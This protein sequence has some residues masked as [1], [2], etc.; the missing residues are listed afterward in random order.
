[1]I[2]AMLHP[3]ID[4]VRLNKIHAL[5]AVDGLCPGE[6]LEIGWRRINQ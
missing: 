4:L 1:M 5:G 6:I 3:D 2:E